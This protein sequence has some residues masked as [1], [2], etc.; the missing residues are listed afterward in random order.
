ME[1]YSVKIQT[2][3]ILSC[4]AVYVLQK[5]I[6]LFF[7][8]EKKVIIDDSCLAGNLKLLRSHSRVNR[9]FPG[10]QVPLFQLSESW[11]TAFHMTMSFHSHA[12]K[13][14]VPVIHPKS[15]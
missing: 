9:P 6:Y 7:N 5:L 8:I 3:V 12:N 2:K 15:H 1:H 10:C 14:L 13:I 4:G 11:C